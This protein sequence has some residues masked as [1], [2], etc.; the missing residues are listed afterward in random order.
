VR[1]QQNPMTQDLLRAGYYPA[2]VQDVLDVSLAGET[3]TAHYVHL[4]TTFFGSEVR[5]HLTALALTATRLLVT[6]VDD[7]PP[8]AERSPAT[9]L[10][11]T[12][13]VPL[14]EVRAVALT[15]EFVR[16]EKH[17]QGAT[18]TVLVLAIGWGAMNRLELSPAQCDDPDC[19]ADHGYSG[20]LAADD[21]VLRVSGEA[22]GPGAVRAAV[23]F[24]RALS[25]ATTPT[26]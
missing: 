2:L 13:A 15:H 17:R 21:L 9:A 11:T 24:A 10:A 14:G 8:D 4:E 6:H 7:H 5:R 1:A 25:A 19:E 23:D 3:V 22:E 12:E 26:G 18:P 20:T 16:P